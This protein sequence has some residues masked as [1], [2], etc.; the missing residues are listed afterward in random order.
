MSILDQ[1]NERKENIIKATNRN[2]PDYVPVLAFPSGGV[3][4]F[5]NTTFR[6][7]LDKPE[8]YKEAMM[9]VWEH[10]YCDC[11]TNQGL[12][13]YPHAKNVLGDNVQNF[14]GPDGCS[15]EHR[16]YAAMTAD[17]YD[18]F[19]NDSDNFVS[20]TLVK[21]KYPQIFTEPM[22]KVI[23]DMKILVD[24]MK[25][26]I[27]GGANIELDSLA[28]QR[29]GIVS[30]LTFDLPMMLNP[31]DELFDFF[32]GFT[33]TVTDIRR[34]G[35]KVKAALDVLYEKRCFKFEEMPFTFPYVQQ[36]AHMPAYMNKKQYEKFFWP[37]EKE[38]IENIHKGGNKAYILL[39]GKWLPIMEYFRDLPKDSVLLNADDDDVIDISKAIG[40]CHVVIGGAKVNRL[41]MG[42]KA[43]N[44]DYT[45]KVLDEC[46][47]TGAFIFNSDK[48]WVC[49]GDVNENTIAVYE[50]VHENGKY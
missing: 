40:D 4:E 37:Y 6:D 16:Q 3:I 33:G 19:I 7:V 2:N 28:E 9:K 15:L 42:N 38:M 39:E 13:F 43:E 25:N 21:R 44:I 31:I 11:F 27:W 26:Y 30:F 5:G 14:L 1:Y 29:Y 8:E 18:D 36:W 47:G 32:R 46:A 23:E 22:E 24:D 41:K 45:K 50:Y 12:W 34:H 48:C 10:I 35:E 20:N 17:D 49:P